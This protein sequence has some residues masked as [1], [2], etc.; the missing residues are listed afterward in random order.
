MR[1]LIVTQ[2][3]SIFLPEI[4]TKLLSD[5]PKHHT[6]VGAVCSSTN[7]FGKKTN[8]FA[9]AIKTLQVFGMRFFLDYSLKFLTRKFFKR[10]SVRKVFKQA[11]IP[12]LDLATSINDESSLHTIS[13]TGP[14]LIISIAGSEIFKRKLIDIP[15]NG[16]LNIHTSL[17]PK[18]RGLM[19]SFWVLLNNEQETGV[20]VFYID[21]GIDS[22][23]IIK[24]QSINIENMTQKE[25]IKTTKYIGINLL[26]EAIE[27]IESNNVKLV[28]NDDSDATYYSFPTREDVEAFV[29]SGKKF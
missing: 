24:Q 17:L 27:D 25:L 10:L 3:D 4:I 13:G 22:G 15:T 12:I 1:L 23:P 16:C 2:D 11:G 19:P 7:P 6:V 21:E 26:I 5:L 9:K 18:Y 8:F 28:S 29:R 14:D 20:S